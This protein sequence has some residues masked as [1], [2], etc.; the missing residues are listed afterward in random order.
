MPALSYD[1]GCILYGTLTAEMG[2]KMPRGAQA[3]W[4][5][6][7]YV[8]GGV[9]DPTWNEIDSTYRPLSN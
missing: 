3:L 1:T 6:G 9:P 5:F 8:N 7:T 4:D 2:L